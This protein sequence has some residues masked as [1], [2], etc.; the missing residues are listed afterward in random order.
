MPTKKS[1]FDVQKEDAAQ[2]S[3]KQPL[4]LSKSF[5]PASCIEERKS[6]KVSNTVSDISSKLINEWK[7]ENLTQ[8]KISYLLLEYYQNYDSKKKR[9]LSKIL[10]ENAYEI[11]KANMR[12]VVSG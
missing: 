5:Q 1:T 8:K 2:N 10:K 3:E 9:Y 11:A 4:L 6:K 7:Q 12:L